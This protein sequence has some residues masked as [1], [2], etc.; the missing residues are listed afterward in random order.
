[1]D[2]EIAIWGLASLSN[3]YERVHLLLKIWLCQMFQLKLLL[4]ANQSLDSTFLFGINSE[5]IGISKFVLQLKL[6]PNFLW[7]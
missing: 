4:A 2:F 7:T 5:D 1:M 6:F 3:F